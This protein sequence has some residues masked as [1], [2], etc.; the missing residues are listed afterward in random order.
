MNFVSTWSLSLA[1]LTLGVND[2]DVWRADLELGP[3][4]LYRL[5]ETLSPDELDR[6]ARFY[7]P[8]DRQ[9]FIAARGILR[10]ILARYLGCVPAAVDFSYRVFGKPSLASNYTAEGLQFN[11]SH[12]GSMALYAVARQREV[13]ID[14][15]RIEPQFAAEGIAEKFF[16]RNEVARLRSLPSSAQL[17]GF[18]NCWTRKEAYVKARGGGLQIPLDSFDVS[19]A[20]HEEATFLSE[21]EFGWSLRALIIDPDYVAAIAVEGNDW[22]LRLRQWQ[23]RP[24]G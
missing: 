18:F 5:R 16:S 15:E 19:L 17:E 12:S 11:L 3:P 14:I 22:Q 24:A 21:G 23:I 20:P 8:E 13:G 6:A 2:V 1:R 10:D 9:R 7:F 4:E